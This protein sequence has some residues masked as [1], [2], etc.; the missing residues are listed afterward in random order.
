MFSFIKIVLRN[1]IRG[2]STEPYPFGKAS[3][4]KGLRGKVK[5]DAHNCVACRMCE[6][7][8]AGGAIQFSEVPDKR[9][10][11]FTLWHNTCAFCGLCEYYCPTKAIHLT[12]D[13]HTAHLQKDKYGYVETGLVKYQPCANCGTPMV[14]VS[15]RLLSLAYGQVN[16]DIARLTH[17]CS[18]CRRQI[19]DPVSSNRSEVK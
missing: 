2:P 4:P 1:L 5:F 8:C 9:G 10:L 3:A 12:G 6:H 19:C 15:P 13:Y 14:P 16:G 18:E 11:K 17:L 7:V